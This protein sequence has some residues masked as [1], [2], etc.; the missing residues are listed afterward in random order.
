MIITISILRHLTTLIYHC[1]IM[2]SLVFC[3]VQIFSCP[4]NKNVTR[5]HCA[6]TLETGTSGA[7][8]TFGTIH[9][10]LEASCAEITFNTMNFRTES[11]PS[12]PAPPRP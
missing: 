9:R 2:K 10:R 7:L 12:D 6:T 11:P 4:T 3:D 5:V 1:A 8:M